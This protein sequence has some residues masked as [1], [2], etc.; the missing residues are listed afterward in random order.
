MPLDNK[1]KKYVPSR[2]RKFAYNSYADEFI[3]PVCLTVTRAN[4]KTGLSE[5]TEFKRICKQ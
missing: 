1:K 5:F 3:S 4:K 2:K